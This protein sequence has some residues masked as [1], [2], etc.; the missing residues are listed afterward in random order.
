MDRSKDDAMQSL[1][2]KVAERKRR[3]VELQQNSAH[4]S[5]Q[6]AVSSASGT[7]SAP[8]STVSRPLASSES[9]ASTS[10]QVGASQTSSQ[11]AAPSAASGTQ[12]NS[13]SSASQ[14]LASSGNAASATPQ[15]QSSTAPEKPPPRQ[16]NLDGDY[17]KKVLVMGLPSLKALSS[18]LGID[19]N[20]TKADLIIRLVRLEGTGKIVKFDTDSDEYEFEDLKLV[21]FQQPA[22][23]Q[24]SA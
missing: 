23:G 17:L 3:K 10:P 5:S 8:A 12:S 18:A 22:T 16:Y 15:S 7:Q 9:N 4:T 14:H 21:D 24:P 6:N 11:N 1:A 20:G 2:A 19:S 13:V